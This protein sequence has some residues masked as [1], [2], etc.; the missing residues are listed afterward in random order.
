MITKSKLLAVNAFEQEIQNAKL[1]YSHYLIKNRQHR[2]QILLE[3]NQLIAEFQKISFYDLLIFRQEYITIN[4]KVDFFLTKYFGKDLVVMFNKD[5]N[6]QKVERENAEGF[7]SNVAIIIATSFEEGKR[8]NSA[9]Y[10]Y[11]LRL[12]L[13]IQNCLTNQGL[14][15]YIHQ[16]DER[17]YK[18]YNLIATYKDGKQDYTKSRI[19]ISSAELESEYLIPYS[20]NKPIHINGLII[21]ASSIKQIKITT[22]LL[23]HDDEIELYSL[24]KGF[25]WN[26]EKKD[27]LSFAKNCLD[28]TNRYF[29]N[30]HAEKPKQVF[31]NNSLSY[32][33]QSRIEELKKLNSLKR[34]KSTYDISRLVTLCDELNLN[35]TMG[36]VNAVSALQRTII[37]HIPPLFEKDNFEQLVANYPFPKS[38]KKSL[39][40]LL[41]SMRP[42]ADYNLHV[43]VSKTDS[44]PNMTQVDFSNDLDV[45]LSEV[46]K[47]LKAAPKKGNRLK[48]LQ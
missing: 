38:V 8:R 28:E 7:W 14:H 15:A 9:K 32:V 33:D 10:D 34:I 16:R 43:Q 2:M 13:F 22:T 48:S 47:V 45:L 17:I 3:I 19:L 42:I 37:N 11:Q 12:L 36:T 30:P 44:L 20:K 25:S 21:R 23:W 4:V 26:K 29:K 31:K 6:Y 41:N 1:F 46:C 24:M 5:V 27:D 40:N 39:G 35:S 18:R